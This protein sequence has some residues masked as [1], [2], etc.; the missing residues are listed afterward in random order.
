MVP[1]IEEVSLSL[2]PLE[3]FE[4]LQEERHGFLLDSSLNLYDLGQY[5]FLGCDPFLVFKSKGNKI[6]IVEEGKKKEC[7]TGNP[8]DILSEVLARYRVEPLPGFPPFIGGAVGYFSYDLCHFL[9]ELPSRSVD[10]LHIPD[11]YLAFY[12][13]L[14]IFD[15]GKEKTYISSCGFKETAGRDLKAKLAAGRRRA[16]CRSDFTGSLKGAGSVSSNFVKEDYLK[17]VRKAKDYISAG[18]IYQVNLSQRFSKDLSFSPFELYKRLRQ[19]NPAPFASFLNFDGMAIVSASPE[20]FLRLRGRKV[21]T[22]PMKG[23]RPRGKDAGEDERLKAELLESEKDKAE[24]VMIVD[25]ERNDLGRVCEYGTVRVREPRNLEP[26]TTVFQ[27]TA[28]VEGVLKQGMDRVNLLKAAFPGGS[29]TGAPK[30]RAMEIIDELEPTR[31]GVYTGGLGYL[32]FTGDLDLSIV[33]RTFLIK[34]GRAYFQVGGGIVADSDP[35]AEYKETLDKARALMEA[36][37]GEEPSEKTKHR[38]TGEKTRPGF[39][40]I[41]H[42]STELRRPER[43]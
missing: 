16:E 1:A 10:D 28:T 31:R 42:G 9:E 14:L 12:D 24:L 11:C 43:E 30:V 6:E 17:A 5:S 33:I 18:D 35:E 15:H 37:A 26:Y 38:G 7:L 8:F 4:L 40:Q 3:A 32:S 2:S 13:A 20:R 23:T 39:S 36:V 34:E 19:I 21:E 27:T 25:L 41:N 29:I 22:R